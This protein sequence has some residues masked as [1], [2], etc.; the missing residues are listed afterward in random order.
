MLLNR[1]NKKISLEG[2]YEGG[3][4]F[5]F[6][7]GRSITPKHIEL[8]KRP[9]I[10]SA[11]IN[12]GGHYIRP[13]IYMSTSGITMPHSILNDASIMKFV[14]SR[15]WDKP[16]Y[17]DRI[18][19]KAIKDYPNVIGMSI[20]TD[21]F[22]NYM[23]PDF[24]YQQEKSSGSYA[25]NSAMTFINVL[26][27]LGFKRIYLVGMDFYE[28]TNDCTYFYERSYINNVSPEVIGKVKATLKQL[29]KLKGVQIY[30]TNPRSGLNF[31]RYMKFEDA[32]K[33]HEVHYKDDIYQD[34]NAERAVWGWKTYLG[35]DKSH[36]LK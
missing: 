15:H 18:K 9:G 5:L 3:S 10:V 19:G 4:V 22:E 29:L 25:K 24:I 2:L 36:I 27:K 35:H 17:E 20:K 33:K 7:G 28:S 1:N 21:S 8:S 34:F 13:D 23:S 32:I 30:N 6:G 31:F 26:V 14:S 11:A 16:L 12:E